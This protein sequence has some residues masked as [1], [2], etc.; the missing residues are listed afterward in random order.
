MSSNSKKDYHNKGQEDA[1]KGRYE[2]PHGV[3]DDLTTWS[4][5]GMKKNNEDNTAYKKGYSNT[6]GQK[7]AT[8]NK[9][10]NLFKE[11]TE[12]GKA[13][14]DSW[15][16]S[17]DNEK[18]KSGCFITSACVHSMGLPDNCA[19]LRVL[20]KFR[21]TY[22]ARQI[23]GRELIQDYYQ[24]APRIVQAIDRSSDSRGVYEGLFTDLVKPT[25]SLIIAGRHEE[26]IAHYKSQV[27]RLRKAYC[28]YEVS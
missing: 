13:Y 11:T 6:K 22:L 10:N 9:Y 5:S 15:R 17:Y 12:E 7:D 14:K 26:A 25:V 24:F 20:R 23:A 3:L 21:D 2:T 18:S 4:E 19:E 8:K 28:P 16:E 27:K 1:K